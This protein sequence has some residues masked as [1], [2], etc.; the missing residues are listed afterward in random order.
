MKLNKLKIEIDIM[1]QL[2]HPHI[3]EYIDMET[4]IKKGRVYINIFLEYVPGGSIES[5]INK[6]GQLSE[7]VVQS[8][9]KQMLSGLIYLHNNNILH[10]DIKCANMLVDVSG[11]VKLADFGSSKL[12]TELKRNSITGVS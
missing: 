1:K 9:T 11:S 2:Q 7:Q 10:R 4:K 8:Y 12:A 3:V 5:L 6:F